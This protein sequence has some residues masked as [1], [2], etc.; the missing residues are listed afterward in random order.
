MVCVGNVDAAGVDDTTGVMVI[1]RAK[2]AGRAGP[3][4]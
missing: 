1:V 2:E 3:L 4:P